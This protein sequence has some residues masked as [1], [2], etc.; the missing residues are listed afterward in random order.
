MGT[1]LNHFELISW[2]NI[3]LRECKHC[4]LSRETPGWVPTKSSDL[5]KLF[6]FP[7]A[8]GRVWE[9]AGWVGAGSKARGWRSL[10][11]G[12]G[13]SPCLLPLSRPD[14]WPRKQALH[15]VRACVGGLGLQVTWCIWRSN[16]MSYTLV[17]SLPAR[18][19]APPYISGAPG[20]PGGDVSLCRRQS[21]GTRPSASLA[22]NA[23]ESF[24]TRT[25]LLVSCSLPL[26]H[27]T[28]S[29][30]N[31]PCFYPALP[32]LVSKHSHLSALFL[33]QAGGRAGWGF[34]PAITIWTSPS[35]FPTPPVIYYTVYFRHA[36]PYKVWYYRCGSARRLCNPVHNMFA[37]CRRS[38]QI[39]NR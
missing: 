15:P 26:T 1:N 8:T 25:E 4:F 23:D 10:K 6:L 2:T 3:S 21:G 32:C 27:K 35:N 33:L 37:T 24:V 36:R 16:C 28:P 18:R 30:L 11:G 34:G 9:H 22:I 12:R 38:D 7:Q 19:A 17:Q 5:F 14:K 13:T 39:W 31:A 20:R 29:T